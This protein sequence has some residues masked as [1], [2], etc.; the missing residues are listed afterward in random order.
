MTVD[1]ESL[2]EGIGEDWLALDNPGAEPVRRQ[3]VAWCE[4]HSGLIL[5]AAN[6]LLWSTL[7]FGFRFG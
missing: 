3:V 2:C 4:A 1:S 5:M 7:V 6:A